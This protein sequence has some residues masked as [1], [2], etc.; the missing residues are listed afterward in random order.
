MAYLVVGR[1]VEQGTQVGLRLL[2]DAL[3]LLSAVAHL[4]NAHAAALP[5]DQ[6]G[7]GL[8][9]HIDRKDGRPRA[10]VEHA[11][12]VLSGLN[13]NNATAH[14]PGRDSAPG[15]GRGGSSDLRLQSHRVKQRW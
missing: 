14:R 3:K 4:H 2:D 10:E 12:I 11:T 15:R 1:D 9:Q 6:V 5:V 8:L 13:L 7:L